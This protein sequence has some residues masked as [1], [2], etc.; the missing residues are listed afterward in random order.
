MNKLSFFNYLLFL[1]FG[2]L[3][4]QSLAQSAIIKGQILDKDTQT[5]LLGA[6][7]IIEGT[8]IGAVADFDGNFTINKAPIGAYK[9]SASSISYNT[10]VKDVS[11]NEGEAIQ[12]EIQLELAE[13]LLETVQLV[14]KANRE[15][16]SVLLMDRREA[17]MAKQSIGASS[18][19]EKGL[20]DAQAALSSISGV[21]KQEG[22]KNIFVRGLGDRYNTSLLNGLP[23]PSEDPEYK[24]IALSFFD[25]DIIKNIH[26]DKAFSAQQNGDVG[27]ASIDIH[28]KSMTEKSSF[29]FSISSGF[30]SNTLGKDFYK[31]EGANYFGFSN[32]KHPS[33]GKFNFSNSLNPKKE[34]AFADLNFSLT[35]GKSLYIKNNQLSFLVLAKQATQNIYIKEKVQN[36]TSDGSIYQN[37]EGERYNTETD[38]M[39]LT[40]INYDLDSK[41]NIA[42]NLMLL[43][44]T[45]Q[46]VGDYLGMHADKFQDAFQER[47]FNRRQ[48]IND[49]LLVTHQI[50]SNWKLNDKL[51]T[52][53]DFSLN[54]I[55]GSEPDR[56]E[57]YLSLKEDGAFGLTGSNR[58]KRFFSELKEQDY[59]VKLSFDHKINDL[60][61]S[62]NSKIS[63]GYQTRLSNTDFEATEYNFSQIPTVLSLDNLDLDALYNENA[64][65]NEDFSMTQG[66]T[67]TYKVDKKNHALFVESHY[68][69]SNS[70]TGSLGFRLDFV[71][72]GVEY[73]VPGQMG[74]NEIKDPFY[75]PSLNLKY[76]INESN[77]LRL[78][79][80]K[81][82]TLPQS[83][84]ISP[85]QYVNIGF[86]S[87]GNPNLKAS[88]NYNID[89]KWDYYFGN[90][91]LFSTNLFYKRILN[92]IGRVDK[93]NSAGLLTY[94]NISD[95]ADLL[96]LEIEVMKDILNIENHEAAIYH[97]ISWNTNVSYIL[98]NTK[99]NLTNTEKRSSQLE[100]ASPLILHTDLTYRYVKED[101]EWINSIVLSYF[102]DRI[103]TIGTL[104]YEDIIEK[105][106]LD[107]NWVSKYKLN[108][109]IGVDFKISNMLNSPHKL[110]RK[111]SQTTNQITLNSFEKGIHFSLGLSIK[112]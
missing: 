33:D 77:S 72:M 86:A 100:G 56:R 44:N 103:H 66:Y 87:E 7:V 32:N 88:D 95:A 70:L 90:S 93:G 64:F 14:T 68:N 29:E 47:G 9:L 20:G 24:N 3:I 108:K 96:G 6:T 98:S 16:E 97:K 59:N 41:H 19:S 112:L 10:Q 55:K 50:L 69:L 62:D 5:P 31:P 74:E 25:S 91:E 71:S 22:V 99:L 76:D 109:K 105:G 78:G 63:F 37:Q 1:F 13:N 89:L 79:S 12:L 51:H 18:M 83:K 48:Q 36:A 8:E 4:S 38:Q 61:G 107:L 26:I 60:I 40:N 17:I 15:A 30:N 21:S 57:N 110:N 28:S 65:E 104:G 80:S 43:H 101:K 34:N 53:L 52:R 45:K 49:N 111:I 11:L 73:N 2:F 84:E 85:F 42:Y 23:I 54:S 58:Q 27:G 46:Y 67:N 106:K 35:G 94:E 75:L 92:P 81:T 102:S 82:Y 39:L